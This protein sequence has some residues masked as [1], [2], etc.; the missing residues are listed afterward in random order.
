MLGVS[1]TH[2]ETQNQK[3]KEDTKEKQNSEKGEIMD[4]YCRYGE[5]LAQQAHQARLDEAQID[6]MANA[7]RKQ[8]T[9]T[10][11]EEVQNMLKL[12]TRYIRYA[13]S[14]L[15]NVAFGLSTN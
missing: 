15:A 5:K 2:R 12:T 9:Q 13:L 7:A 1:Q 6:R 4:L 11:P 10:E 14:T 3:T 8:M